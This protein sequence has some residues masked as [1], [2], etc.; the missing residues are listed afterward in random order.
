MTK[1][2]ADLDTSKTNDGSPM[3]LGVNLATEASTKTFLPK[4]IFTLDKVRDPGHI[5]KYLPKGSV[6]SV[7]TFF[8]EH[9]LPFEC[10]FE[11]NF[12]V[13]DKKQEFVMSDAVYA[14]RLGISAT[15]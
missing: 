6:I 10:N 11:L 3:Q 15:I 2:F 7:A 1:V 8:L 9:T 4:Y 5:E 12:T 14:G 13:V